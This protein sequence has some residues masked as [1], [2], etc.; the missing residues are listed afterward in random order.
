METTAS[1]H[2]ILQFQRSKIALIYEIIVYINKKKGEKLA[3]L[4][5][6]ELATEEKLNPRETV[7][8]PR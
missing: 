7:Q 6:K 4:E 2:I 8:K 1:T 5:T 3:K